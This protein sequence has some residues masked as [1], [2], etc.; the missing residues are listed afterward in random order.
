MPRG[1]KKERTA[2]EVAEEAQ[3]YNCVMCGSR[4]DKRINRFVW[5]S[6]RVCPDCIN[7]E[8]LGG[9]SKSKKK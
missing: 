4:K 1:K 3:F 8:I 2:G 9:K 7:N 6:G 5:L